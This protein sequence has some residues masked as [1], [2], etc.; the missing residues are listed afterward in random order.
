M[1]PRSMGSRVRACAR[2]GWI[3]PVLMLTARSQYCGEGHWL[4]DWR[5]RL[6]HQAVGMLG[7][8]RASALLRRVPAKEDP[9]PTIDEFGRVRVIFG[10]NRSDA[11]GQIVGPPARDDSSSGSSSRTPGVTVG[12]EELADARMGRHHRAMF[13]RTVDVHAASLSPETRGGAAASGGSSSP[14]R[15]LGYKFKP[16]WC[17]SWTYYWGRSGAAARKPWS[18]ACRAQHRFS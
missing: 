16:Q 1:L 17:G 8:C 11:D 10:G 4:R 14:S 12:R 9:P 5:R 7:F 3:T 15:K 2:R 18:N 6:R 13:T